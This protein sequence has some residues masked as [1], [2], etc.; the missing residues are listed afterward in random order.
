M[1]EVF[2]YT[3]Y[4]WKAQG[5]NDDIDKHARQQRLRLQTSKASELRGFGDATY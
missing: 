5:A 3:E 1:Y 4:F 2:L